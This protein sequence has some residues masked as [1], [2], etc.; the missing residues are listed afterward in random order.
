LDGVFN[1]Q[2]FRI[3]Q[4]VQGVQAVQ[5]V[6][7]RSGMFKTYCFRTAA[8]RRPLCP[9]SPGICGQGTGLDSYY[10]VNCHTKE[11]SLVFYLPTNITAPKELKSISLFL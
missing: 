4:S 10:I 5:C 1:V 2:L 8:F 6:Q 11:T 3:V 7:S 9:L